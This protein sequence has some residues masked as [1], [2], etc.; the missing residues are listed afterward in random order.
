MYKRSHISLF[1]GAGG[2]DIGLEKSGFETRVMVE[3]DKDCHQTLLLNHR[4]NSF[5]PEILG[6][7]TKLKPSDVLE[8]SGGTIGK[9]DLLSGGPPCQ[10]FSTAGKRLSIRDPRGSLFDNF[11]SMIDFIQPR[12]FLMENVRG[13][14]SAAIDHRP[15]KLRG[16]GHPPLTKYEQLGS[17]FEL[18][19]M[20]SFNKLG[21]QV[22]MGVLNSLD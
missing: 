20:P 19:I 6:D 17:V 3:N 4:V 5:H 7:I 13:L 9:I 11:V 10:S 15:L 2:L 22:I 14:L 8:K 16:N 21:Y 12:F 1:S 18:K